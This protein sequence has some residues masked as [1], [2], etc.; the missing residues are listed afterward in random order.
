VS[1]ISSGSSGVAT[2]EE[3]YEALNKYI[4]SIDNVLIQR[5]LDWEKAKRFT[6]G[7][8]SAKDFFD[9]KSPPKTIIAE[10]LGIVTGFSGNHYTHWGNLFEPVIETYIAQDLKC[11]VL[12][13]NRYIRGSLDGTSYSPDG[14]TVLYLNDKWQITLLEFKCPFSRVPTGII[15]KQYTPQ[16]LFGLDLIRLPTVGL[17]AEAVFRVSTWDDL[18]F[19]ND[20]YVVYEKQT[21]PCGAK[22]SAIG[23]VC[24]LLSESNK[25][26]C[27]E[28][29]DHHGAFGNASNDY[30]FSDLGRS[31]EVMFKRVLQAFDA[32]VITA[33]YGSVIMKG[34]SDGS[35][36]NP[37]PNDILDADMA[38]FRALAKST[39]SQIV[40]MLPYKVFYIDYITV[41]PEYGIIQK[42]YPVIKE[43]IDFIRD[44][45]N[46]PPEEKKRKYYARY[47]NGVDPSEDNSP[48]QPWEREPVVTFR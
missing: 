20:K 46:A 26:F 30:E 31:S 29:L 37:D 17:Y 35:G 14:L 5:S 3:L 10:K 45:C 43:T 15:P 24:F 41:D 8:S 33:Y 44:N 21:L 38:R 28:L 34:Y 13:S 19:D 12:A 7:G 36:G 1:L 39:N 16:L 6:V 27:D 11:E 40:G 32:G 9:A 22:I 23:F 42:N 48:M 4:S 2:K 25:R 47:E 18:S